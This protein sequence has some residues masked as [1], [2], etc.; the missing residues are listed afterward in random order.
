MP[1]HFRGRW[2]IR[3][4]DK[5]A[6]WSQRVIVSGSSFGSEMAPSASGMSGT[7]GEAHSLRS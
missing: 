2:R 3:V 7:E 5:Q 1:Q 6:A 4:V